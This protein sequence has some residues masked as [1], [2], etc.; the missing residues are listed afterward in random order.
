MHSRQARQENGPT[1][2]VSCADLLIPIGGDILSLVTSGMYSSPLSVYR[3][4]I[5][6]SADS[7]S[8]SPFPE[9]G[10]VEIN[11]SP[12]SMYLS[13]RD[14]G[15][16][17]SHVQAIRELI[18]VAKSNKNRQTDRGFR[19]IGRLSG[20]AFGELITF[21]TRCKKTDPI[22]RVVWEGAKLRRNI[23]CGLS[24]VE[25]IISDC[26]TVDTIDGNNYPA[27]F[28]EV[29]IDGISRYASS[30]IL[31]RDLVREYIGEVCPVPF[32]KDFPYAKEVSNL[33]EKGQKLFSLKILIND[34]ESP[35]TKLY[36]EKAYPSEKQLD[37]FVDFE[38]IAIPALE[39]SRNA[40]IGWIAH[41]L[42]LGA[43]PQRPSIRCIRARAG[44]IQIGD[45][46]VFD[47]LF[48]ENRFNRWCV[49]EIHILDPRIVPNAKRDYFEPSP[50]LRNLENHLMATC[51]RLERKCRTASGERN[52]QK[53]LQSFADN[54]NATY[55]L[56]KSR[57]LTAE[58]AKKLIA[59]K[60]SSIETLRNKHGLPEGQDGKIGKLNSLENKLTSFKAS[61]GRTSFPGIAPSEVSIYKN[62]FQIL[63]EVSPSPQAAKEIINAILDRVEK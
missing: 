42:Y 13:I 45:E 5:Q 3:E 34:E 35:I 24:S 63:A 10:R 30:S 43:L 26:V 57:Y 2:I 49:S 62:I 54:V 46:T 11:I 33:F 47:H 60:L 56:A 6:N 51:R 22:T 17:L 9:K 27:H 58:A 48:S 21:L 31:N 50:H 15:P 32:S 37:M 40:A 7:I 29:Q 18:P 23:D 20:L 44:N 39:S 28:F 53:R 8:A 1:D 52:E 55:D 36:G 61:R 4:Y 16:G 41:S 38:K 59:K 19:G 25:K 12:D 14:N